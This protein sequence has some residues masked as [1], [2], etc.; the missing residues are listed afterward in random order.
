MLDN[1]NDN[2]KERDTKRWDRL[3]VL[4]IVV[5]LFATAMVYR[6][7]PDPLPTHFD[8]EGNPN[9][10]LPRAAGAWGIPA[11]TFLLWLF[12]RFVAKRLPPVGDDNKK[13]LA[14]SNIALVA[15][16]T[17]MFVSAVHLIILYVALKPGV[18]VTKPVF[19]LMGFFFIGLGL[20]LPRVRR[21]PII[22]IRTPWTLT[23]DENWARTNRIAGYTMVFGGIAGGTAGSFGGITGGTLAIAC[24]I[25]A[26]II[27]AVYSLVLAR[28]HDPG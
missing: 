25:I 22:G 11:F 10:W 8:L 4:S 15:M 12:V 6:R 5:A 27:P 17:A 28:R 1:D 19:A 16:M 13:R 26:S 21:N 23:S 3:A 2:D 7:L 24:F 18:I 20:V 14:G 9:G